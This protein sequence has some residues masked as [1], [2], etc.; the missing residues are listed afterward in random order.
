MTAEFQ[1]PEGP[2]RV[3]LD[4]PIDLS[5]PFSD[6]G[7]GVSAWGMGNPRFT[8]VQKGDFIGHVAEGAPVNFRD[9]FL[10]PHGHGTHTECLGHITET[11]HSVNRG[12]DRSFFKALL[13]DT[14]LERLEESSPPFEE[15]DH[16]ILPEHLETRLKDHPDAQALVVRIASY[17]GKRPKDYTGS[18]PPYFHPDAMRL[19]RNAGIIHLLT[20]LPSV[21]KESDGGKLLSHH[22][23]WNV[24]EEPD[25]ERTITELIRIPDD[26]EEGVYL[27][28]LQ[29][30]PIENDAA[31]SRPLLFPVVQ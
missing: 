19:L 4:R 8:P 29:V 22:A 17:P 15:G 24:P 30:A 11:V 23:F 18:D 7:K 25:H 6:K 14:G 1:F 12:R 10:N 13:L 2:L 20:E 21:D 5:F 3:D 27:L 26:I 16:L 9:L 31:P 28:D